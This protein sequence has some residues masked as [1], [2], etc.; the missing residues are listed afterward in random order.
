MM[1]PEAKEATNVKIQDQ[2]NV[3]LIFRRQGNDLLDPAAGAGYIS[4]AL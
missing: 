1:N 2:N 3:D 4:H